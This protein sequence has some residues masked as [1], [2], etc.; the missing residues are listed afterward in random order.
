MLSFFPTPYKD[1][2]LYS[3]CAR[4]HMRASN[5]HYSVTMKELFG[6]NYI[7]SKLLFPTALERLSENLPIN[8][9]ITKDKLLNECT[10]FNYFSLFLSK[11]RKNR[12]K[13]AMI[14][15]DGY[16]ATSFAGLGK[17]LTMFKYLRFCRECVKEDILKY[18]E[19]YWHQIHQIP[20]VYVCPHHK[21]PTQDS[22]CVHS[23]VNRSSF[24]S[25]DEDYCLSCEEIKMDSNEL[26][27]MFTIACK[28]NDCLNFNKQLNWDIID[29]VYNDYL[30]FRGYM[31][32]S[33][34]LYR[35]KIVNAFN[36]FYG[37]D[38]LS[39]LGYPVKL[40][41]KTSWFFKLL[42]NPKEEGNP[43]RHILLIIFLG[44]DFDFKIDK[45]IKYLPFGE[46]PWCCLNP[47]CNHYKKT[48]NKRNR[49]EI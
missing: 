48:C 9:K 24:H 12:L 27:K 17:D 31:H 22:N 30:I 32:P 23:D 33:G 35:E 47:V 15:N 21:I 8:S 4:Y 42:K 6:E 44:L 41:K 13:N 14:S 36:A 38:V 45:S 43:I 28:I 34:R 19:A 5:L 39:K 2:I 26:K 18:G 49:I 25:L 29:E 10:P 16:N 1:E 46:G 11:E 20:G 40:E 7:S 37:K 3:V